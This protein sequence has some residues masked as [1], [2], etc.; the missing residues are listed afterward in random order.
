MSFRVGLTGGIGS[1]K[2]TVASLFSALG[3]PLV[4]TDLISHELTRPGGAAIPLIRREFGDDLVDSTGALDRSQ[5]RQQVFSDPQ[6]KWRLERILHPLIL[7][8]ARAMAESS[9]APYVMLVIPLLFESGDYR[10][11]LDRTLVVDCSE[12]VQVR[13]ATLRSGLNEDMVRAI[14]AQQLPRSARVLLADDVI[15]NDG[16]LSALKPQIELLHRRYLGL[17]ERS[18]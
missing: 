3:V 5:M 10:H 1:G 2:S 17:S 9:A 8:Q 16:D 11:W 13:R 14:M 7:A 15:S 6:A 18:N 12:G 4:D